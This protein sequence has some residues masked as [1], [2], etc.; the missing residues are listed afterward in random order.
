MATVSIGSDE[1]RELC[2]VVDEKLRE[3]RME[4]ART[5]DRDYREDLKKRYDHL[6]A[7]QR[8]LTSQMGAE[9][10]FV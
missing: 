2:Q 4:I 9:E 7:L 8:K 3:M 6:E 10:V 1:A 5:D